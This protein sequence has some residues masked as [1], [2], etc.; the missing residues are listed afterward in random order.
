MLENMQ[1]S[2]RRLLRK[3]GLDVR[4]YKG[5][6]QDPFKD[7]HFFLA[8]NK[9]PV[10]LDVG[11]NTGESVYSFKE[12]S[13]GS[14]IHSFEPS[15]RTYAQLTENCKKFD[16]V[17]TWNCG[18]GSSPGTLPFLENNY[19]SMSSF[20][21][22]G[23]E[24]DGEIEMTTNVEV[25]TLDSFATKQNVEFVHILKSDTQGYD[26]HV[27]KGAEGLMKENRIGMIYFE[28]IFY[29]QYKDLP[30]FDEVFRFLLDRNF[31]L[32]SFYRP[33]FHN[34]LLG[35]TDMLFINADYK[36]RRI[37]RPGGGISSPLPAR[38]WSSE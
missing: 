17:K 18:V 16:N 11:A 9:S 3:I 27:L 38:P 24:A 4:W 21:P 2:A 6:G 32:V 5:L 26:F 28:F 1:Q 29:K 33:F 15:P 19:S 12:M 10:I 20:L 30:P 13:P 36:Q 37:A 25:W 35:W 7:M 23:E 8:G 22:P 31:S 14:S 34:D